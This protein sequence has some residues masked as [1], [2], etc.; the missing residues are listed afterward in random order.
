VNGKALFATAFV[1]TQSLQ[2]ARKHPLPEDSTGNCKR[3]IL[4][5]PRLVLPFRRMHLLF[6]E[7]RKTLPTVPKNRFNDKEALKNATPISEKRDAIE[8]VRGTIPP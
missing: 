4:F 5:C 2:Q 8:I 3:R 6:S 1:S 7:V